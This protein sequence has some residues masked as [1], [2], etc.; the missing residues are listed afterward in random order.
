MRSKVTSDMFYNKERKEHFLQGYPESIFSYVFGKVAVVERYYDIDLCDFNY[1]Q[2]ETALFKI[3]SRSVN[4][5][6]SAVRIFED[7]FQ[8]CVDNNYVKE[9]KINLFSIMGRDSESLSR[10]IDKDA[11][12][13]MFVSLK[14]LDTILGAYSLNASDDFLLRMLWEGFGGKEFSEIRFLKKSD[15]LDGYKVNLRDENENIVGQKRV[16]KRLYSAM[17]DASTETIYEKL[18]NENAR[19]MANEQ[20]MINSEYVFRMVRTGRAELPYFSNDAMYS[21]Y[22]RVAKFLDLKSSKISELN[23]SGTVYLGLLLKKRHALSWL[24]S[25]VSGDK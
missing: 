7:Y 4:F 12:D 1:E 6:A 5:L 16:S 3:E 19:M 25:W 8:F 20:D 14:E 24:Q 21:R 23:V 18:R 2:V 10:F 22:N 13:N 9:N 15:L 11:R 17:E